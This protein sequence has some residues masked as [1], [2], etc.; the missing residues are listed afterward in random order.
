MALRFAKCAVRAAVE[1][2]PHR[3]RADHRGRNVGAGK[4]RGYYDK[5]GALRDMVQNHML[6]LLCLVAMEPPLRDG[7]RCRARRK[8]QGA[9]LAEADRR[10]RRAK[11][12]VRGQYRAGASPAQAGAG[13]SG[14]TRPEARAPHRDL[15]R[16]QG[17]DRQLALGRRALLP[18]HRQ[19][20][21]ERASEIVIQF[22][23]HPAF[24]LRGHRRAPKPNQLVI[25]LQPDEGV[26]L[27]LMIKDP[28][29]GGMRLRR[30]RST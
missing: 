4:T 10:R 26:K 15:R 3:P 14:G 27:F 23:S 17:R 13:L 12:T 21:A 11:A 8:A 24:D 2:G 22:R 20:P 25:R 29:P 7:R 28:G 1:L 30:C 18:A 9:A 16:H 5:S 19:A 6:Q